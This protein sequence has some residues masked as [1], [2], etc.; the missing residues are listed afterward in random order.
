MRLLSKLVLIS[1][2]CWAAGAQAQQCKIIPGGLSCPPG[3]KG[4]LWIGK[5]GGLSRTLALGSIPPPLAGSPSFG[6]TKP[7]VHTQFATVILFNFQN[8]PNLNAQIGADGPDR[9]GAIEPPILH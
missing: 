1:A 7:A 3:S 6:G 2:C 9:I 4:D 8:N 5:L